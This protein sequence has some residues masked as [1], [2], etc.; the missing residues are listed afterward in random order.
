MVPSPGGLFKLTALIAVSL[1]TRA[2]SR[3]GGGVRHRRRHLGGEI[4]RLHLDALSH[5]EPREPRHHQPVHLAVHEL[6]HRHRVVH[7]E[8]L[9]RQARLLVELAHLPNDN[10]LHHVRRL[11]RALDLRVQDRHLARDDVLGDALR[12]QEPGCH[13]DRV[14]GN[15]VRDAARFFNRNVPAVARRHAHQSGLPSGGGA[16]CDGAVHVVPQHLACA[17]GGHDVRAAHPDVLAHARGGRGGRLRDRRA[18][19]DR[20]GGHGEVLE[21]ARVHQAVGVGDARCGD[22]GVRDVR[23]EL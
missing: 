16:G 5:L 8:L 18:G 23:D 13:R 2:F 10:L 14:H 19:A 9:L 11:A 17:A 3:L 7:H 22:G 1:Q 12:V 6:L 4:L 21:R 15:L 20:A